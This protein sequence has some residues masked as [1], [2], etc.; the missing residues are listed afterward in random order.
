MSGQILC[1]NDT[2]SPRL[3]AE[4][5]SASAIFHG[6]SSAFGSHDPDLQYSTSVWLHSSCRVEDYDG[7]AIY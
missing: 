5:H 1:F 4:H 3:L 7:T 2:L 6:L